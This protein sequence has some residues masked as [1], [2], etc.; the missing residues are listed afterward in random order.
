MT[1]NYYPPTWRAIVFLI[2]TAKPFDVN[3][4]SYNAGITPSRAK[5]VLTLLCSRN[6]L[7]STGTLYHPGAGY[8]AWRE[9][10]SPSRPRSG[11]MMM[12]KR[13]LA[14]GNRVKKAR[15]KAG[16]SRIELAT[17]IGISGLYL[18]NVEIGQKH[19]A[20]L[21]ERIVDVLGPI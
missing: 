21:L 15:K 8:T 9:Q 10:S 20:A 4:L 18:R 6:V 13:P 5:Q 3:A 14:I 1:F 7:T 16:M 12:V 19:G 11:R 2:D 17:A